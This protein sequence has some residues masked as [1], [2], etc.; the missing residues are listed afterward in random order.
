M[1]C[2]CKGQMWVC[3]NHQDLPWDGPDS[4]GCGAAAAPCPECNSLE[5]PSIGP[6]F[7]TVMDRERG[8]LH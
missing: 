2:K 8:Y 7:V 3:E 5:P 6:G 4:C 1:T